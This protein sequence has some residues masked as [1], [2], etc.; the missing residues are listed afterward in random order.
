MDKVYF[1][2]QRF[3][4]D[5]EKS[6]RWQTYEVP[7]AAGMTVLDGL[8]WIQGNQDGSLAYRSSCRAGV[9]GSCAMHINGRYRL[10]CETQIKN[11]S[12]DTVTLRPLGHLPVIRDLV[13]DMKPFWDKYKYIKPYL[14]PGNPDPEKERIQTADE[15]S[16]IDK[17]IDC[18]LCC[19]CYSSCNLTEL[20]KE[21]VGPAAFLKANRFL[22][23][24]RDNAVEERLSLVDGDHG[25]WR[26]HTIFNCQEVCPKDLNPAGG[27]AMLKREAIRRRTKD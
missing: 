19:A 8:N 9:C 7:F 11:L 15:R 14:M 16:K 13:V 18:I 4:P 3:D 5:K 12:G 24:S 23:D 1:K 27:I 25:V 21:Y 2:I 20:D 6:P 26:C 10:A 17:M 22:Q